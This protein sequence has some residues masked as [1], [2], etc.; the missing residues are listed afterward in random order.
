MINAQ[1]WYETFLNAGGALGVIPMP[2]I[3][4]EP[5]KEFR[6]FTW[7]TNPTTKGPLKLTP[8]GAQQIIERYK[9]RAVVKCFDYFHATYDPA[10][11]G[12]AK[13]AAGQFRPEV[14]ADGLWFVDIQWTPNAAKAIRDGEWPYISPAVVHTKD[15]VIID[16]KNAG[17]VTD[18]GTI[19]ATPT[20]LS[21]ITQGQS[22]ETKKKIGLEAYAAGQTLLR[23]MQSLADTDGAEKDL[24]NKGI[25]HMVPMMDL[26]KSAFGGDILAE[27]SAM[28]E[29]GRQGEAALATLSALC[30]E[31]DPEKLA[32]VVMAKMNPP[33][34]KVDGVVLSHADVGKVRTMLLDSHKNRYPTQQRAQLESQPLNTVVSYLSNA[35]E[36][37]PEVEVREAPPTPVSAESLAQLKKEAPVQVQTTTLSDKPKSIAECSDAQKARIA[38]HLENAER[39]LGGLFNKEE[40]TQ[41]ALSLLCAEG[42]RGNEIRHLPIGMQDGKFTTLSGG[43]E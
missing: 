30:G 21:A 33:P 1:T 39:I 2:R 38:M 13:K 7:G 24:G 15:G 41:E 16:L 12:E 20:I 31:S 23:C 26:L 11:T 29:R 28:M 17:L 25:S 34:A 36:I 32:G 5:P 19:G 4:A 37:V 9:D 8:E 42:V 40:A 35:Q 14:R 27:A 22:M 43:M 3:G 18:P 6:V 10:A